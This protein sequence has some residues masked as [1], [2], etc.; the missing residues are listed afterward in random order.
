VRF[1][2]AETTIGDIVA[3]FSGRLSIPSC[4]ERCQTSK[5]V[6]A[7][8]MPSSAAGADLA[9]ERGRWWP[10]VGCAGSSSGCLHNHHVGLHSVE[11]T[12]E[13]LEHS[14]Y[15]FAGSVLGDFGSF[16]VFPKKPPVS[17]ALH[18][19]GSSLL[20]CPPAGFAGMWTVGS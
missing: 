11:S 17:A 8:F 14:K 3:G 12:A 7:T 2:I 19:L 16:L 13:H 9:A 20:T 10:V 4:Q 15:G 5:S 18:W 1:V 6:V